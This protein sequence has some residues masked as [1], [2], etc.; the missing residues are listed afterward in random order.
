M[1]LHM[2]PYRS[3]DDYWRIRESLRGLR[4]L[5]AIAQ[6]I[7]MIL[8]G[9]MACDMGGRRGAQLLAAFAVFI[10]PVSLMGGTVIMY[11]AF[12]YLW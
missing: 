11:F 9:L 3:E 4:V 8:A 5:P 6:G 1:K 12:D 2:R 10:A 7:A